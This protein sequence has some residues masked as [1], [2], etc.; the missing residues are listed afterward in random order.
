VAALCDVFG[1]HSVQAV[2]VE[3]GKMKVL[4]YRLLREGEQVKKGDE[5]RSP[6]NERGKRSRWQTVPKNCIGVIA[7]DPLFFASTQYRRL[8]Q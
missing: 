8:E 2:G 1:R 3:G 4:K 5:Y 7:P 6:Q